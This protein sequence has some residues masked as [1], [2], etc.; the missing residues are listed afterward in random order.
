MSL[1]FRFLQL[2]F[3]AYMYAAYKLSI[4][5]SVSTLHYTQVRVADLF[6]LQVAN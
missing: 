1:N 4:P 3:F 6:F 2:I 5:N